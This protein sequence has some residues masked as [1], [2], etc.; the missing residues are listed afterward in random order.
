MYGGHCTDTLG[1]LCILRERRVTERFH[2]GIYCQ[3]HNDVKTFE[4][5]KQVLEKAATCAKNLSDVI[6]EAHAPGETVTVKSGGVPEEK[7]HLQAGKCAHCKSGHRWAMP[8]ELV[9]FRA[10]W[11]SQDTV[12][13]VFTV[14][15]EEI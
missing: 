8:E 10:L 12:P 1:A 2:A 3:A 15:V 4:S 11:L 13:D 14:Q 7:V 9:L 6:C 5:V